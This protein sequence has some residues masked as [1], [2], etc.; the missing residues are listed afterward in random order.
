MINNHLLVCGF[1]TVWILQFEQ[2]EF[3]SNDDTTIKK[4]TC[5]L[6]M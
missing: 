5:F 3:M 6:G 1:R 2:K 4:E